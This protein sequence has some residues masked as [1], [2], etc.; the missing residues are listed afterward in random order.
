MILW[1]ESFFTNCFTDL[2]E[3]G[4][5]LWM[6]YANWTKLGGLENPKQESKNNV[7]ESEKAG[8]MSGE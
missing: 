7:K 2:K 6:Q 8:K 5:I 1:K 4:N 3:G